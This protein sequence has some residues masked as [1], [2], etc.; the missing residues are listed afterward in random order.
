[1][2]AAVGSF[3]GPSNEDLKVTGEDVVNRP[4]DQTGNNQ[5]GAKDQ[6]H[7]AWNGARA[8]GAAGCPN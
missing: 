4:G 2:R 5:K 6:L 7:V 8:I 3:G 1:M